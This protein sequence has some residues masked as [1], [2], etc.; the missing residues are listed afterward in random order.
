[1]QRREDRAGGVHARDEVGH[2]DADLPG[3]APGW[4]SGTPVTLMSPEIA[5]II[6]RSP[7]RSR[8]DR[9]GRKPRSSNR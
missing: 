9:P 1:M 7:A 5:W 4:P 2:R 3:P 8:Q 6:G